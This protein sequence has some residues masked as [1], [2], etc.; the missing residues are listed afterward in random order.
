MSTIRSII[1]SGERFTFTKDQLESDPGNYFATYL[2][3][4]FA[5]GSQGVR[6]LVL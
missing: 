5:E 6:E 3:G 2:F 4:G 1:V